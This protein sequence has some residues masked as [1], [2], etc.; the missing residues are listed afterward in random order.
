[1][2]AKIKSLSRPLDISNTDLERELLMQN[3]SGLRNH[4]S[5]FEAGGDVVDQVVAIEWS[6]ILLLNECQCHLSFT[7]T[8]YIGCSC[9]P[10]RGLHLIFARRLSLQL[11][12][13][14]F[15]HQNKLDGKPRAVKARAQQE[16]AFGSTPSSQAH[17]HVHDGRFAAIHFFCHF[18]LDSLR[19]EVS[20]FR[21]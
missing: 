1:M 11:V 5:F 8:G 4:E 3:K 19:L 18:V 10:L 12:I 6:I 9:Q 13:S 16:H 20:R 2:R 7:G 14:R 17:Q 15:W 21:R